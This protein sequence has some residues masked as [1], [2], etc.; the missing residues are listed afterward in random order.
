MEKS[1]EKKNKLKI[2][3]TNY[4]MSEKIKD[5]LY[6]VVESN[7]YYLKKIAEYKKENEDYLRKISSLK[8][9]DKRLYFFVLFC[10]EIDYIILC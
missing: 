7:K 5:E 8:S 2:G 9:K 1:E 4:I 6:N 3:K 10:F